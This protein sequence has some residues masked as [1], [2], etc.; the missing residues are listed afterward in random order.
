MKV[1]VTGANG[2]L[3]SWLTKA[4][5]QDGHDVY[6][7]VR[8]NSDLSELKGIPCHYVYGDVT[9]L[10]SLYKAFEGM[11]SIFH[12][13]GLVA[14]KKSE[15]RKMEK[16]NV[17]GTANVI[18]ACLAKGVRRLV[19]MSSVVAVGSSTTSDHVL[20]ENSEYTI[21]DLDLGYFETKKAAEDL[22]VK[23][24]R[25]K[26]L[27]CVILNPSTI[28]GEGDAKKGSR[29]IQVKVAQG[30]FKFYTSGGVSIVAVEDVV[31]ATLQAWK[32]GRAGQRYILAGENITIKKLF[33]IIAEEAGVPAPKTKLPNWVLFSLGRIGDIM[34]EFGLKGPVSKENA[35]T[36]VMYHWFDHGK[37]EKDL[38]FHPRP[39]KEAIHNSVTWMKRNGLLSSK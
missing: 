17:L 15:R 16:I 35:Q 19:H 1:L 6:A 10:E 25:E 18:E 28:Y 30:K 26:K 36:S 5:I 7:L 12:L 22:V 11:D 14:Y 24:F 33:E 34:T 23:A 38:D 32:K 29:K 21:H 3:G 20:D 39:A 27:D 2:F 9:D 4:L 31:R 37:A 13:A 8:A